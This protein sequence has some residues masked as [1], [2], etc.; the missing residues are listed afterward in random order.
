MT[1]EKSNKEKKEEA[2]TFYE[3][4]EGEPLPQRLIVQHD[5]L[6]NCQWPELSLWESRVFFAALALIH[7]NDTL[8]KPTKLLIKD[9]ENIYGCRID[10]AR[11]IKKIPSKLV[12]KTFLLRKDNKEFEIPVFQYIENNLLKIKIDGDSYI[13]FQINSL[14]EDYLLEVTKPFT[15]SEFKNFIKLNKIKSRQLYLILLSKS[16]YK[17]IYEC[18]IEEL[19]IKLSS[20][21]DRWFNFNQRVLKPSIEEINLHTDINVTYKAI[22]RGRSYDR[23]KF[24]IQRIPKKVIL[25]K[26]E[27]NEPKKIEGRKDLINQ[28]NYL[29]GFSQ[30]KEILN[31]DV[32]DQLIQDLGITNVELECKAAIALLKTTY[33]IE[34][35]LAF[36]ISQVQKQ[37]YHNAKKDKKAAIEK[38]AAKQKVLQY[39][40]QKKEE[41]QKQEK[42]KENIRLMALADELGQEKMMSL[43]KEYVSKS[44]NPILRRLTKK[45]FENGKIDST[46]SLIMTYVEKA[47]KDAAATH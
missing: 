36:I 46:D 11:Q 40:K 16:V 23:L 43:L 21:Y 13:R 25:K 35:Q 27:D 4:P 29:G 7:K 47:Y 45:T 41:K 8:F 18:T 44:N 39:E 2:I 17:N 3:P 34:K 38:K 14:L 24:I 28:L 30:P 12:K 22:K 20:S 37:T 5:D 19:M 31:V 10:N 33:N 26:P 32:L 15:K 6:V 9:L 1:A 42:Q